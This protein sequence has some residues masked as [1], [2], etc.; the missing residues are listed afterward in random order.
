VLAAAHL[1]G[2]VHRDVKPENVFLTTDAKGY[3]SVKLLDFGIAKLTTAART[4]DTL[5]GLALGTPYYMSPEQARGEPP[6]A[7]SD[8]WSL[9]AVMFHALSGRPPHDD[10]QLGRLLERI[11]TKRPPSLEEVR[12]DLDDRLIAIV[13]RALEPS[14]AHRWSSACEMLSAIDRL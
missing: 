6:G 12:P 10:D 7:P 8:L 1:R 2:I 4:V 3:L 9:G 14:L 11:V 13:D 5:Q